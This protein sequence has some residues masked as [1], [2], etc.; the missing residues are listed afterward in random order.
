M[1]MITKIKFFTRTH[2]NNPSGLEY[3]CF[4]L[5]TGDN[6]N[7]YGYQ[8]LFRLYYF[9]SKSDYFSIGEVKILDTSEDSTVLPD[10]FE[11]LDTDKFCSL[12]QSPDY[13]KRLKELENE[14]DIK[15]TLSL[16]NDVA[17]NFGL[18]T[19]FEDESGFETSLLRFSEAN[20]ALHEGRKIIDGLPIKNIFNF[21]FTCQLPNAEKEHKISLNFNKEFD[22]LNRIIALV[23]KNGTGK[24]QV[25]AKLANSLSGKSKDGEFSI[26]PPFSKVIAVTYSLFDKFEIPSETK[27]YSYVYCGIRERSGKISEDRLFEKLQKAINKIAKKKRQANYLKS[28]NEIIDE[29]IIE[30]LLDD[31]GVFRN[32]FV[33]MVQEKKIALS[34]GQ[35][36]YIY[37]LSEIL[38]NIRDESLLLFDEPET[39]LHPNAIAKIINTLYGILKKY[40]SYAIVATHSPI[41]I[42]QIPARFVKVFERV[43]NVPIIRNLSLESFGEN[44]TNITNEI[45]ETVNVEES[46]KSKLEALSEKY[47]YKQV[48]EMF[49]NKLSFNAKIY[50]RNLYNK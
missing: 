29:D 26:R 34:S 21:T 33:D 37:I 7:D 31:E 35:S 39:H 19:K 44:L 15:K 20:K 24:T 50:L 30:H 38:A 25:L 45:F 46:Y 36:I 43:G 11:D 6:W 3:P 49:D 8:T 22:E 17:Y 5:T 12:G 16:L 10:S 18:R 1:K 23:G 2:L 41:I 47:D 13:Y 48:V 14:L 42:Q 32:E 28:L 4:L 9:R 40:D 27:T